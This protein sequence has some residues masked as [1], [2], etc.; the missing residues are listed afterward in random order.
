M[1]GPVQNHRFLAASTPFADAADAFE[2]APS[3]SI[4]ARRQACLCKAETSSTPEAHSSETAAEQ[5][6][7][8]L[9]EAPERD[10]RVR[11]LA[12]LVHLSVSQL[13]RA[14]TQC[15]GMPP[16]RYL[17]RV[18]AYRLAQLLVETDLPIG[19]AMS[20]V[21]WRSRGHAARQFTAVVG[22]SPSSYRRTATTQPFS[23]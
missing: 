10:W 4:A 14:F 17:A 15:F 11:D 7:R 3:M 5:A 9:A 22:E 18:R 6:A 8:L 1:G 16:M 23:P 12:T 19:I 2:E 13:G 20:Q 21:G